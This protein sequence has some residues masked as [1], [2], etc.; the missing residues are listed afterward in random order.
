MPAM[1]D[2]SLPAGH[3]GRNVAANVER[4]RTARRLSLRDLSERLGS[5]GHPMLT[6]TVH[7]IVQGKRRIDA[8]DLVALA[9]A[10]GVTPADLLQPDATATAELHPA[11]REARNLVTRLEQMLTAGGDP[12]APEMLSGYLDRALRR[13]QIEIEELL[14]ESR[15][16]GAG[17]AAS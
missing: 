17:R 16:T 6:S 12:G 14:A 4:L 13:V 1:S 15:G 8:D 2:K 5:A 9:G 10:L 11:L 3:A 7:A